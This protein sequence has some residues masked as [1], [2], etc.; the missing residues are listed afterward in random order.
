MGDVHDALQRKSRI[1]ERER[2]LAPEALF[3]LSIQ[4]SMVRRLQQ[5]L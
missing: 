3:F 4:V 2:G 5:A 1:E